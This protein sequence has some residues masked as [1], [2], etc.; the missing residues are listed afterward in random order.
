MCCTGASIQYY[1]L[2]RDL[3]LSCTLQPEMAPN[4]PAKTLSLLYNTI[5]Q[6][7]VIAHGLARLKTFVISAMVK[8]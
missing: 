2:K 7:T 6:V 1:T 8:W 5:A 4:E 3:P